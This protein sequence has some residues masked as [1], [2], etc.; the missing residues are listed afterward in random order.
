MLMA[1]VTSTSPGT[2]TT[3]ISTASSG[4]KG[5]LD[6]LFAESFGEEATFAGEAQ[7]HIA[8]KIKGRTAIESDSSASDKAAPAALAAT[9]LSAKTGANAAGKIQ[10]LSR[11]GRALVQEGVE[12]I[13][14]SLGNR[15]SPN[16]IVG[17]PQ[18]G[19]I[20]T[21]VQS[22]VADQPS[23]GL[24]GNGADKSSQLTNA[25][26]ETKALDDID[27]SSEFGS[28][29]SAAAESAVPTG[30]VKWANLDKSEIPIADKS[31]QAA[32]VKKVAED[33]SS[34]MKAE[35]TLK[36]AGKTEE[37][38]ATEANGVGGQSQTA[39]C[40]LPLV[41]ST[42]T[43]QQGP[44]TAADTDT[45]FPVTSGASG[46]NAG[47]AMAAASKNNKATS[48]K[49]TDEDKTKASGPI[50][51]EDVASQKPEIDAVKTALAS[52]GNQDSDKGKA[53]SAAALA[54]DTGQLHAAAGISGPFTNDLSAKTLIHNAGANPHMAET[55]FHAVVT[56][57]T[58]ANSIDTPMSG[59][60]AHK[61]LAVTPTSLEVGVAGGT[62]GWLKI[63]A[64]ITDGGAVNTSLSTSSSAGQEMLHRELSSLTA[65]LQ[66]EHVAV[67]AVVVQP[68]ISGAGSMNSFAGTGGGQE[69][70]QQSNAQGRESR[71]DQG[72]ATPSHVQ[73]SMLYNSTGDAG[74][75]D[76][77]SSG[78]YVGGGSWLSVRA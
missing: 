45:L 40:T 64:E 16:G 72:S 41:C 55:I 47:I 54:M 38:A 58:G 5:G 9:G 65:F 31:Q 4:R 17:A 25:T 57:Q 66:S 3:S 50:T 59:D 27:E 69:Q 8:D 77:L 70:S 10:T 24:S 53:Q 39:I 36:V 34:S 60:T 63:R 13:G 75:N 7:S 43:Q 15:T 18:D 28:V 71:Q 33:H 52:A 32:S 67:N 68:A 76:A 14:A 42:A 1:A 29:T 26:T 2:D 6:T 23:T 22:K 48:I 21:A 12:K 11:T 37:K 30:N 74:G 44:G 20:D 46:K 56:A 49:K 78:L 62:H 19:E 73:T 61:T 35:K 51:T